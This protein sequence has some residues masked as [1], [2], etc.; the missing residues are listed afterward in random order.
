MLSFI[1]ERLFFRLHESI[2]SLLFNGDESEIA[3]TKIITC[4]YYNQEIHGTPTKPVGRGKAHFLAG[5]YAYVNYGSGPVLK[6]EGFTVRDWGKATMGR[7]MMFNVFGIDDSPT[8]WTTVG[9]RMIQN[10]N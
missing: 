6:T 7:L 5:T 9:S 10:D 1:I 3:F 8:S 2:S 4:N